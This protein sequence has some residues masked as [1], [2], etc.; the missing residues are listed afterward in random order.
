MAKKEAEKAVE[1]VPAA[2]V[3]H[4]TFEEGGGVTVHADR[5]GRVR[6]DLL[7]DESV[8]LSRNQAERVRLRLNLMKDEGLI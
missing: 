1:L 3:V 7:G 2:L 6:I 8:S 4:G 5:S